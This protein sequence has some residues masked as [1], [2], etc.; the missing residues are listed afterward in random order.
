[1]APPRSASQG[2][3]GARFARAQSR[4]SWPQVCSTL[5]VLALSDF[6]RTTTDADKKLALSVGQGEGKDRIM[7]RMLLLESVLGHLALLEQKYPKKAA[8]PVARRAKR[9][10]ERV[11]KQH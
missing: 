4:G 11:R 5:V 9:Y 6:S 10:I 1:M 7:N 8:L 2:R 3:E